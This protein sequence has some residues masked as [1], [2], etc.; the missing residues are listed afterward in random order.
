[1]RDTQAGRGESPMA[2]SFD[3]KGVEEKWATFWSDHDL[4]HADVRSTKPPFVMV[5]PPPNITGRLHVGHG[6]N[7]ALQDILARWKRMSGHDVLWIPGSDHASIATHVMIERQLE[8]EGLT[9][10]QLGREAF[11]ERAWAWKQRFGSEIVHQLRQLGASCDWSR[12]RFTMDSGLSHAVREVFVRLYEEGLIYRGRYLINWCPRCR[13]AVSDLE[14]VH[15]ETEGRLYTIRYPLEGRGE[16]RVATTR[17]ETILGDAA[18]AVHPDDPRYKAMVGRT[19]LLPVLGRAIPIVADAYVDPEFGTGA[20]KVTPAHDPK[21]FDAGKRLGLEPIVV[22]DEGARMTAAAG[23]YA[24][25][26]RFACR[27]ALL[28]RLEK[29]GLLV[30]SE[31]HRHAVGHC[32]RCD[33]VVEPMISL[34]WFVKMAPL[35]APALAAVEQGRI[36]LIPDQWRKT[37]N[38]WLGNIRDWCISRQL[39]W[40]HRIP[41]WYCD[42]CNVTLV[43]RKDPEACAKCAGPLRQDPDI[44]D[45]WFSSG[46]W[47][48]STMGWP[49][50]TADLARYYPTHVLVTGYDIVFFWVARMVMLSLKFMGEVPF[51][52]V[53]FNGLVRDEHG[54]K[55]SKTKGNVIDLFDLLDRYGADAVRF[56]YAALTTPGSDVALAPG[57]L[58]GSRNFANK[59]WN[60]VRFSL[61]HLQARTSAVPPSQ[62]L[63]TADRWILSRSSVVAGEVSRA[64]ESY[65]FDEAAD[66]IYHFAWHEV[67]DWYIE[68]IKIRLSSGRDDLA[69]PARATLAHVLDR[70]LKMLHPFMPFLTEEL[71]QALPR[72]AAKGPVNSLSVASFPVQEPQYE[73]PVAT[74]AIGMLMEVVTLRRNLQAGLR[75]VTGPAQTLVAPFTP[76][77]RAALESL[78][79][80][81]RVLTRSSDVRIV[82]ALDGDVTAVRGVTA[83]AEVAIPLAKLDVEAERRRLRGEIERAAGE[84]AGHDAKLSNDS[85]LTRAKPDAVDKVKRAHRELTDRIAKL[86]TTLAQLEG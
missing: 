58:E 33:T 25:L 57:R 20:V 29:D 60:V 79:E 2:K 30:G 56:T 21:D 1:M 15:K 8:S 22:M 86:K 12:E 6:L 5:I 82:T 85:F 47:A 19:V 72:V 16:I 34:Q 41:A 3:P 9:R 27:S 53:F 75:G 65:R 68:I 42:R 71:W 59:M 36:E 28:E 50:K 64:L 51:R 55:I 81:L 70:L 62:G 14:V 74:R 17:P 77:A 32:Q 13:T 52:K 35:A 37:Y 10:Q 80:E 76:E 31:A 39:W 49:E 83:D 45:T 26:D 4:F 24:G 67:C 40:G 18:V 54:E 7:N 73:D 11:L 38:E 44:L 66:A 61:P 78:R 23:P 48:F 63:T 84:L 46:L 43:A 69:E